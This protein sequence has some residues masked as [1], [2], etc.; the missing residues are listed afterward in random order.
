MNF[1]KRLHVIKWH[2]MM[3]TFGRKSV[4]YCISQTKNH[5]TIFHTINKN[6]DILNSRLHPTA[7]IIVEIFSSHNIQN[8]YPKIDE[9]EFKQIIVEP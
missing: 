3:T 4:K 5:F 7:K 6:Y 2:S 9:L 1:Y 8:Y